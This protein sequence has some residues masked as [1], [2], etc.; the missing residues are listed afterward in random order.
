MRSRPTGGTVAKMVTITILAA[1]AVGAPS[2]VKVEKVGGRYRL[3]VDGKP[4]R[5]KGSGGNAPMSLL[6]KAG[7]NTFRTWGVG[8]DTPATLDE[9]QRLGVKVLLGIWLGHERH[10]FDYDDPAQVKKQLETAKETVLKYRDHPALLAWGVGN[11]MEEYAETTKPEVWKAVNEV[12]EMIK[13]LDPNHPTVTVIAEVGGDR[14]KSINELCPAIDVVGVNSYGGV[15]SLAKRYA[16]AGG[17]KPFLVTEF[18][19]AGTWEQPKNEWGVPVEKTSTEKAEVYRRIQTA[20]DAEPM[21]IGAIAFVWGSKQEATASWFGLFLPDITRLGG[22]DALSEIWTGRP[23]ANKCPVISAL[24]LATPAEVE[25]GAEVKAV[26]EA[27]DP[28]GDPVVAQWVLRREDADFVTGGDFRPTPPQYARAIVSR[29]NKGATIKMPP[30]PGRY[31]LYAFVRDGQGGGATANV[32][33]KVNGP[34][35]P[36]TWG[37]YVE[38]PLVVYGDDRVESSY[39][40]SGWMGEYKSISLDDKWSDGCR[41]GPTCMKAEYARPDG[42]A[43][44]VWQSPPNDWGDKAGGYRLAGAK[45]LSFW[46]RGEQGGERIKFGFGLIKPPKP[47]VDTAKRS[48][49]VKLSTEWKQYTFDLEGKNLDRIKSGFYW[50]AGGQGGPVTFYLDDIRYD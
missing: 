9:A 6:K 2:T 8:D 20:L 28:E 39:A 3:S 29:S 32:P 42:W 10:G 38:L 5:I 24:R 19:P 36:G 7:G 50:V 25:P 22:V 44:V 34:A 35:V 23:V 49:E 48:T 12:A 11:E 4:F 33:L 41:A 13:S 30:R 18:G 15:L 26:L 21:C 31:R 43:G 14:I 45:K 47:F 16:D 1:L 37:D 46:A 40:P 27:S 17:I